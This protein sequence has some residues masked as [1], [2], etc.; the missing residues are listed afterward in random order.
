M[1]LTEVD[2]GTKNILPSEF[3]QRAIFKEAIIDPDYESVLS[4]LSIQRPPPTLETYKIHIRA[5]GKELEISR[6]NKAMREARFSRKFLMIKWIIL[7]TTRIYSG[8]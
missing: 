1:N 8:L 4:N 6:K 5:K 2:N 3:M 7:M